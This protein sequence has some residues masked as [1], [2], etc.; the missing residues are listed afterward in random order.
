MRKFQSQQQQARLAEEMQVD[1]Q[2]RQPPRRRLQRLQ[3]RRVRARHR[4]GSVGGHEDGLGDDR[5]GLRRRQQR[6][7]Q[8]GHQDGAGSGRRG[9]RRRLGHERGQGDLELTGTPFHV[10]YK[11][12]T[13]S[14]PLHGVVIQMTF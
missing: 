13:K 12:L 6:Q 1:E 4:R 5:G 7:D 2:P 8:E 11:N 3:R 14:F 10:Q 9:R